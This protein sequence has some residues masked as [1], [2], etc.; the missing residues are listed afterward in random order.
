MA[1]KATGE[2]P[3]QGEGSEYRGKPVPVNAILSPDDIEKTYVW[4]IDEKTKLVTKREVTTGTLTDYGIMVT[5]GL[6]IGDWIA[7]AGVHNLREGMEVRILEEK[8]K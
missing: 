3:E 6:D 1:G 7:I 2:G 4:I 8:A 5:A